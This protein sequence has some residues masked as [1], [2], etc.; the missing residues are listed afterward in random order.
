M[1]AIEFHC[2]TITPLIVGEAKKGE[3]ELRPPAIKAALRFWWRA[4]HTHLPDIKTLK[5][6]EA[7]IFGGGGEEAS[8]AK[9]DIIVFTEDDSV[10]YDY[11]K[12]QMIE[13]IDENDQT[14]I[15]LKYLAYSL[16]Y[17]K[18]AG[19][20][21]KSGTKFSITFYFKD[22]DLQT[23]KQVLASFCAMVMFG[24]LGER[25]RRGFGSF[26]IN[27]ITN[28]NRSERAHV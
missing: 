13:N 14:A 24:N 22:N 4:M 8:A 5:E 16:I 1:K 15:G 7:M 3:V 28:D 18:H 20:Y 9:F 10:P 19:N 23:P 11:K 2:R 27:S 17:L 6:Q 25:S 21:F 26:K 12:S